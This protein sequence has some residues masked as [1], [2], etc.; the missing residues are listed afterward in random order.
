MAKQEAKATSSDRK[1]AASLVAQEIRCAASDLFREL[2]IALAAGSETA[3]QGGDVIE[4]AEAVCQRK[5]AL[6]AIDEWGGR[7]V[8]EQAMILCRGVVGHYEAVMP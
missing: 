3:G 1:A 7:G 2:E 5:E 4:Q 6:D 8:I